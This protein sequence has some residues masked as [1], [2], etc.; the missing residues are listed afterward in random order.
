[1]GPF[2]WCVS[3]EYNM[4]PSRF[5]KKGKGKKKATD[6]FDKKDWYNLKAP[7]MFTNTNAGVTPV[8][9]TQGNNIASDNLKGRVVCVN[10]AELQSNEKYAHTNIKLKVDEIQGKHCLTNFYGLSYTTDKLKSLVK[11]WQTLVEANVDAKTT[12]GYNVRMF[13]IGFTKPRDN[14]ISKACYAQS[15]KVKQIRARMVAVM[16]KEATAGDLKDLV[17]K[18]ISNQ[19]GEAI[20]RQVQGI[21]PMRDIGIRKVKILKAPRYDPVKLLELHG[22]AKAAGKKVKA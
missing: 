13:C 5:N 11:K 22:E 6:P 1:M 7:R 21:Y 15:S 2:F 3:K 8:N 16:S 19:I 9:R 12:D 10:L 18:L 4:P 17:K 14:Q 20:S